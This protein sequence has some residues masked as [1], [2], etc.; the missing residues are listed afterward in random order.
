MHTGV[1]LIST[2]WC[3]QNINTKS[4]DQ[5]VKD[6]LVTTLKLLICTGVCMTVCM[7]TECMCHFAEPGDK[8]V[9]C[10]VSVVCYA[11]WLTESQ[12]M[13][14]APGTVPACCPPLLVPCPTL[15]WHSLNAS[16][17]QPSL[18][19]PSLVAHKCS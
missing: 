17:G 13:A 8:I 15:W 3:C 2:C 16:P 18:S 9:S 14:L 7:F 11:L 4:T 12:Y 5:A 1:I 19:L 6:G 10:S